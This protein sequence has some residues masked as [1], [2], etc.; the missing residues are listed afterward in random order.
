[1]GKGK[2]SFFCV[3]K[4]TFRITSLGV[5]EGSQAGFS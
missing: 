1:M 3:I 5:I 2:F 4:F